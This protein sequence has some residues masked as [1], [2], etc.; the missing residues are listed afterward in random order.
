[1]RVHRVT[2]KS[3]TEKKTTFA[4][5]RISI[6]TFPVK[7]NELKIPFQKFDKTLTNFIVF[8]NIIKI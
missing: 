4:L 5:K 3:L 1:M 7:K 2:D 8:K 6:R